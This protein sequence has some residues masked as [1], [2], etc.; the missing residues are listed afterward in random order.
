[1]HLHTQTLMCLCH[2]SSLTCKYDSSRES[3]CSGRLMRHRMAHK[4]RKHRKYLYIYFPFIA[5]N[6]MS[7]LSHPVLCLTPA[8]ASSF[9]PSALPERFTDTRDFLGY[10]GLPKGEPFLTR[11][12]R[13][14]CYFSQLYSA[15]HPTLQHWKVFSTTAGV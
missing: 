3:L 4:A 1:M 9:H 2:C 15:S 10:V 12:W 11:S 7:H 13:A 14:L 5:L 6:T 8:K